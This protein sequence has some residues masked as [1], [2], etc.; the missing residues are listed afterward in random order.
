MVELAKSFYLP[1]ASKPEFPDH[2]VAC[3][4]PRPGD[5]L[6]VKT[7]GWSWWDWFTPWIAWRRGK[8]TAEVPIC[9][10][11]RGPVQRMR[12]VQQVGVWV[13]LVLA[14]VILIPLSRAWDLPTGWR[15]PIV[16]G[17]A[18]LSLLP[19]G[20]LL[21]LFPPAFDLSLTKGRAEYEFKNADYATLFA[22]ANPHAES[23]D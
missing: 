6:I 21:V 12:A 10:S 1:A 20:V 2:C 17:L 7:S 22:A 15:R 8:V 11:C 3:M 5:L 16:G 9:A 14:L 23:E 19:Y 18:L 4:V 13:Y